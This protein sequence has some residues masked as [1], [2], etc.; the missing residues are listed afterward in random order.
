MA[1]K[2][3]SSKQKAALAKGRATPEA[4]KLKKK[5]VSQKGK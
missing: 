5:L 4:Q 2:K 3:L 1:K